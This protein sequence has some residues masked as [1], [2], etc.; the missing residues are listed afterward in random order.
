MD[1]GEI[2]R[3]IM[4]LWDHLS[5]HFADNDLG[6]LLD[7]ILDLDNINSAPATPTNQG[8]NIGSQAPS[9]E[10]KPQGFV[11]FDTTGARSLNFESDGEG[12]DI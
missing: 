5:I 8:I 4:D 6:G 3:F 7:N 1:I 11:D 2:V 12:L 10:P 9:I